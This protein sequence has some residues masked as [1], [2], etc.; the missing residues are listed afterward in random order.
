MWPIML[1]ISYEFENAEGFISLDGE[2]WKCHLHPIIDGAPIWIQP[3]SASLL[4]SKSSHFWKI[5]VAI[6]SSWW[7]ACSSWGLLVLAFSI[8]ICYNFPQTVFTLLVFFEHCHLIFICCLLS[9]WDFSSMWAL[10]CDKMCDRKQCKDRGL[11]L[12]HRFRASV[13]HIGEL[14]A[15]EARSSCVFPSTFY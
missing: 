15:T 5:S 12:A 9:S 13:H 4:P 6:S 1:N 2:F 10:Q 8:W 3:T 11:T 14:T 7:F